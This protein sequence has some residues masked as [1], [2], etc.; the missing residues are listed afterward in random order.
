ML[1]SLIF[2]SVP[3]FVLGVFDQDLKAEYLLAY[4]Q[5]FVQHQQE[6]IL[7]EK[8]FLLWSMQFVISSIYFFMVFLFLKRR[9]YFIRTHGIKYVGTSIRLYSGG[10]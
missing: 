6:D 10:D 9:F 7:F 3:P 5:L 8:I 4:P 2:T 1:Y